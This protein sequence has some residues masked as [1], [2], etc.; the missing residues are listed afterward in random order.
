MLLLAD[1]FFFVAHDSISMKRRL[2]DRV[3][4]LG[5][6]GALLGEQVLFRRINVRGER[7][8]VVDPSPPRDALAHTVLDHLLAEPGV[9][10]MRDW[11]RFFAQDAYEKVLQ[12]LIREG[13]VYVREERRF[14]RVITV[15][16][17]TMTTRAGWPESRLASRLSAGAALE[18]PDVV[19]AGLVAATG[20]DTYVLADT[21]PHARPYLQRVVS[22]LPPSLR[23][24]VNQT[25]TAV[26]D[27]VLNAR[28]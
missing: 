23:E 2:A 24:V 21:P 8:R 1:D 27:A 17:P 19:L 16:E 20:L 4:R 28:T 18:P 9:T 3:V 14:L 15:F 22:S 10:S 12:R 26:G 11:L 25:A 5:L 7:I 13:H 6:A